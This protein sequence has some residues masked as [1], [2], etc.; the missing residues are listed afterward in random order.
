MS[1]SLVN[2][3][4]ISVFIFVANLGSDILVWGGFSQAVSTGARGTFLVITRFGCVPHNQDFAYMSS[5]YPLHSKNTVISIFGVCVS[6][7]IEI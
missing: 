2:F 6:G 1:R 3:Y 7:K 5:Q 4:I